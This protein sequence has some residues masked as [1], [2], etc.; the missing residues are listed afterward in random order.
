[1]KQKL[2]FIVMPFLFCVVTI[3]A[4]D[5]VWDFG[6]D[7]VNWPENPTALT[8]TTTVDGLTQVPEGGSGFGIVEA[9]SATWFAGT[10]DEYT[11][12]NR[13]KAGGNSGID[14]SDGVTFLPTRRYLTFPV[15]GPVAVKVWFRQSGT[16]T[17]RDLWVTDG[18]SEVTHYVGLGDTDPQYMEADYL[19]GAGNLY[20]LFAGN[21]YNLYKLEISSTLLGTNDLVEGVSTNVKAI[22]DTVYVSNV[23]S[24]SEISIYALTG[25]LVKTVNTNTDTSFS[26]N[27]G[28][29]IATIK[30]NEGQ[31]SVKLLVQ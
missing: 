19:G 12:V 27:T 30:T 29:Y 23:R 13:W 5:K 10:A 2:L 1:M 14:P 18:T 8:E 6:N 11:S 24:N 31:K 7:T 4:Q 25:A 9:N 17:P 22:G 16:S 3:K 21:A 15:D 20:V 28:F 26:L